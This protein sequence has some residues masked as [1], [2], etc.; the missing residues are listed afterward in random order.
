MKQEYENQLWN[1]YTLFVE[2]FID[3]IIIEKNQPI[4]IIFYPIK[5]DLNTIIAAC[6]YN[7]CVDTVN[8][9]I[10]AIIKKWDSHTLQNNSE[11]YANLGTDS[12]ESFFP[13][14][15]YGLQLESHF[16]ER[17]TNGKKIDLNKLTNHFINI[18]KLILKTYKFVTI[19]FGLGLLDHNF[20]LYRINSSVYIIDSYVD[21]RKAEMRKFDDWEN[22][23]RIIFSKEF[24]LDWW[25]M[26]FNANLDY[27]GTIKP[28]NS[29]Y[30]S[31]YTGETNIV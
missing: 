30:I 21:C 17:E 5:M 26:I 7:R 25:N 9:I 31:F 2:Y 22:V 10:T 3:F 20:I 16:F 23:L 13:T 19:D 14:G 11:F 1:K 6:P 28:V 4:F 8:F 29:F 27:I 12:I 24:T 15:K 18:I